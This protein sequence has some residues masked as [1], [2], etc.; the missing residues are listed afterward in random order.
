[1]LCFAF[2]DKQAAAGERSCDQC[3]TTEPFGDSVMNV[4]MHSIAL[5]L[6]VGVILSMPACRA[7]RVASRAEATREAEAPNQ[8]KDADLGVIVAERTPPDDPTQNTTIYDARA[9]LVSAYCR[10][11]E[12]CPTLPRGLDVLVHASPIN[13]RSTLRFLSE[14][15]GPS[16]YFNF[17]RAPHYTVN[18]ERLSG[19]I[20]T[21]DSGCGYVG[22]VDQLLWNSPYCR[23]I[24]EPA[25]ERIPCT[26]SPDCG[27]HQRCTFEEDS[28]QAVCMPSKR[29]PLG[30]PCN[31]IDHCAYHPNEPID[32]VYTDDLMQ[33]RCEKIEPLQVVGVDAPCS[34][35]GR[36]IHA[37]CEPGLFCGEEGLCHEPSA[38][39]T[40][41]F[42]NT[43]CAVGSI[44]VMQDDPERGRC[45]PMEFL[46]VEDAPCNALP[47]YLEELPEG[48]RFCDHLFYLICD[49]DSQ[50]CKPF[51]QAGCYL[52]E[53]CEEGFLC[54][55]DADRPQPWQCVEEEAR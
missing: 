36:N 6:L 42:T 32:C 12:R 3:A 19:C 21:I 16:A 47:R 23:G 39:G 1:M 48:P 45:Q 26:S 7:K 13:C 53:H 17:A 37:L 33:G 8:S 46:T 34:A 40:L 49:G 5:G 4:R 50:R 24:F 10:A 2:Y 25:H 35:M 51:G 43:A 14:D 52:D 9:R 29:R 11:M 54:D 20:Q 22:F 30:E 18:W 31:A 41:C 27:V 15:H 38:D 28:V 44:C 55:T